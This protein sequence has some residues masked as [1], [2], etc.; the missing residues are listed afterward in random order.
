MRLMTQIT[1]ITLPTCKRKKGNRSMAYDT[2][3]DWLPSGT[4]RAFEREL[5]SI[6]RAHDFDPALDALGEEPD[7][8]RYDAYGAARVAPDYITVKLSA[9]ACKPVRLDRQDDGRIFTENHPDH[10][11][12]QVVVVKGRS[13]RVART[14]RVRRAIA[15]GLLVEVREPETPVMTQADLLQEVERAFAHPDEQTPAA[16]Q[17]TA[18]AAPA[19][20]AEPHVQ[21]TRRNKQH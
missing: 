17:P 16:A 8:D 14:E 6:D 4:H 12:G 20:A 10:P 19:E 3:P 11:E 2:K 1:Q 21:R 13:V 18:P 9:E 5:E 15:D 7:D